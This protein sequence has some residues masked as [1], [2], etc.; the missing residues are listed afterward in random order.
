MSESAGCDCNKLKDRNNKKRKSIK[1]KT[2][3]EAK[4]KAVVGKKDAEG[5]PTGEGTTVSSMCY[6]NGS[7]SD[8]RTAH[9][10]QK[11]L[12]N[13]DNGL[14]TGQDA[15]KRKTG[16]SN[17]CPEAEHTHDTPYNQK[18]AHTEAR[19]LD[20]LGKNGFPTGGTLTLNI[21]WKPTGE[22][23]ISSPMP[24]RSCHK[25][26]CAARKCVDKVFLC[27]EKGNKQEL[28][29]ELCEDYQK[30]KETLQP[31]PTTSTALD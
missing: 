2:G 25:L 6:Q 30:L 18:S 15:D 23:G 5:N 19:L 24:C 8:V 17:L 9:N 20:G 11:A 21:D 12:A 4:S 31:T 14:E 28:T 26:L 29:D 13:D 7:T 27:D 10:S 3:K 1:T 22:S 16:E